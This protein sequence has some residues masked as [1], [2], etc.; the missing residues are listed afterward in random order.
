MRKTKKK[1]STIKRGSKLAELG[2]TDVQKILEQCAVKIHG[3]AAKQY[4][5]AMNSQFCVFGDR[6]IECTCSIWTREE[7]QDTFKRVPMKKRN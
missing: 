2:N 6:V 5:S 1:T 3:V 4:V 7:M